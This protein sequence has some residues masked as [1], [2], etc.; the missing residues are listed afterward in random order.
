LNLA[1]QVALITARR[2]A[3]RPRGALMGV[4][5]TL[6]LDDW[7]AV[8][9]IPRFLNS[10]SAMGMALVKATQ[11]PSNRMEV[12]VCGLTEKGKARMAASTCPQGQAAQRSP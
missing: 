9:H 10:V 8:K 11:L 1:P 6:K 7:K 12:F 2:L 3:A 5:L 4:L